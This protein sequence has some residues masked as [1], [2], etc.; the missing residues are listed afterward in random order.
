MFNRKQNEIDRLNAR[1]VELAEMVKAKEEDLKIARHNNDVLIKENGKIKN[2]NEDLRSE[3]DEL[4]YTLRLI[5]Q[6]I[7][8][9]EY[10]NNEVLKRRII[11]LSD[12]TSN[13]NR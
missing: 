4:N 2:E 13:Q 6:L 7:T 1:C 12:T 5:N 3:N 9:N 10:N 8:G 11:E